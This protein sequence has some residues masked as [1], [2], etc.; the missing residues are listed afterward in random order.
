MLLGT[1]EKKLPMSQSQLHGKRNPNRESPKNFIFYFQNLY[2]SEGNT[3]ERE[4]SSRETK[5]W[6]K[7]CAPS[8]FHAF[9]SGADNVTAFTAARL[10]LPLAASAIQTAGAHLNGE[11]SWSCL[12]GT[13]LEP[14]SVV[15]IASQQRSTWGA[16]LGSP[17]VCNP[18]PHSPIPLYR[19]PLKNQGLQLTL[20]IHV[21]FF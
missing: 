10:G 3:G 4:K 2:W 18:Q 13:A 16:L 7:S 11:M 20:L 5:S 9:Q 1:G 17:G 15:G 6:E 21:I 14:L 8:P 19:L 12:A